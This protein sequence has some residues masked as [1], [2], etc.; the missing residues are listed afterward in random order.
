MIAFT[1]H[2][3]FCTVCSLF[4]SVSH[5][6]TSGEFELMTFNIRYDNPA[7]GANRWS[8]R[9]ELVLQAIAETSP[10]AIAIQEA[11]P[12]QLQVVLKRFPSFQTVGSPRSGDGS[13]EFSGL[14]ID[15]DQLEVLEEG[16]LWL[17]ETPEVKASVGWDA[18]LTRTATWA[19]ARRCGTAGPNILLVGTH[20][21][22]RG[23]T[24][25]TKS[26]ELIVSSLSKWSQDK[27]MAVAVMGDLNATLDS[28]CLQTFMRA[29]LT[30]ATDTSK[31]TFHSFKG[32]DSGRRIDYI[33]LNDK[34]NRSPGE[35]LRPRKGKLCASD[36][37][38]VIATVTP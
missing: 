27:P 5:T 20:F 10:A 23:E 9:K 12:H 25:R 14:L 37:D 4:L 16:Q 33:L 28:A 1:M 30:P 3:L 17:S 26:A 38:P 35:I 8:K 7:D 22:H 32:H 13:G 31:G 2:L 15:T 11:L 29:G 34:W 6:T 36:H 19:I 24:A 18:A 21:D